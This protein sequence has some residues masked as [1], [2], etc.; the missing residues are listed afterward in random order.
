MAIPQTRTPTPVRIER[1]FDAPR[2][3]VFRAWTDPATF[4]RWFSDVPGY[5]VTF[6]ELDIREG[7]RFQFD[8]VSGDGKLYR[9]S[10]EYREIR[11]P[12]R[13]VFT[14]TWRD[15]PLRGDSA[16]TTVTV[17]LSD[18]GGRTELVLTHE[19]FPNTGARD[20]HDQG[21]RECLDRVAAIL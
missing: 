7:G 19:G 13:L 12:D 2:E 4:V 18:R 11:A 20:E 10:G 3:R 8:A 15:D 6:P 9:V 1:T 17:E 21:W 14:W 5:E 16:D